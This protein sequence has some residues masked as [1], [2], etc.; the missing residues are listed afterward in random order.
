MPRRAGPGRLAPARDDA[1]V[2]QPAQDEPPLLL[3]LLDDRLAGLAVVP[4]ER[5]VASRRRVELD[6]VREPLLQLGGIGERGP[7]LVGRRLEVALA[8]DV[9]ETSDPQPSGCM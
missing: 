8:F 4:A 6:L 1:V 7:Y 2:V 3:D 5:R 9:H